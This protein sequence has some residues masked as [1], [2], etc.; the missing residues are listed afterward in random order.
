VTEPGIGYNEAV[1]SNGAEYVIAASKNDKALAARVSSNG[2]VL[3]SAVLQTQT[4]PGENAESVRAVAFDGTSYLVT[5]LDDRSGVCS[6]ALGARVSRTGDVLDLSPIELSGGACAGWLSTASNGATFLAAWRTATGIDGI[7]VSPSGAL[8]DATSFT[9]ATQS[10]IHLLSSASD[11]TD[12]LV[13]WDSSRSDPLDRSIFGVRVTGGGTPLDDSPRVIAPPAPNV[14]NASPSVASNGSDYLVAWITFPN[15]NDIGAVHVTGTGVIGPL[16]GVT[17]TPDSYE[18]HPA[19]ASNGDSYLVAW[20]ANDGGR[21]IRGSI[22][23]GPG[24]GPLFTISEVSNLQW[25]PSAASNG[26]S[27]LV[28]WNDARTPTTT[29]F[30]LFAST[31]SATGEI[32]DTDIVV[33]AGAADETSATVAADPQTGSFLLAYSADKRGAFRLITG[34][35]CGDGTVDPGE[36]CDDGNFT[37]HDGCSHCTIDTDDDPVEV[38]EPVGCGCRTSDPRSGFLLSLALVAVLRRRRRR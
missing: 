26:S 11:G 15:P 31:V 14:L 35:V 36:S 29:G 25:F 17:N 27:Y 22:V 23:S 24:A 28:T 8:V 10:E 30:D 34:S 33:S 38:A 3:D 16:L 1:A 37:S 20:G 13:V 9:I 4:V 2:N 6:E 32:L 5:W 12:Y 19:V 7:R 18:G 21:S